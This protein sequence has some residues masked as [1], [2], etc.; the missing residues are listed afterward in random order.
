MKKSRIG[1]S[2]H[3]LIRYMERVMGLDVERIRREIGRKVDRIADF[4]GA[5]AIV[6]DGYAYT[7]QAGTVT[8]IMRHHQGGVRV[9]Q[10]AKERD[11]EEA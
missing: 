1:V 9:V 6:I 10:R 2:D 3:A 4:D 7:V 8:T 11:D 5:R